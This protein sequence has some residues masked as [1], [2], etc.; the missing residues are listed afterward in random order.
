MA[1]TSQG[2][3]PPANPARFRGVKAAVQ[4]AIVGA[5]YRD[6]EVIAKNDNRNVQFEVWY[7]APEEVDG[8]LRPHLLVEL[9]YSPPR[10]LTVRRSVRSFVNLAT[11]TDAEI[12]DLECV[13]IEETAAEK[14]VSLTRRT[15]GDLEGTKPDAH[16]PFLV[17]H[18]YDL[19]WLLGK[20]DRPAVLQLARE[21]ASSDAEQFASWFPAYREDPRGWTRRA[22]DHL[23]RDAECHASYTLFLGRMVYGERTAFEEAFRS[24]SELGTALWDEAP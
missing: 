10:L 7:R 18:V 12:A 23:E 2:S 8:P 4:A 21:I 20:V 9:T 17:R 5:G 14:L 24:V 3:E 13:S 19:H 11:R 22:L 6:P 1:P 16:D 15:A